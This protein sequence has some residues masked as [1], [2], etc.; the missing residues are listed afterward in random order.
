ML[1]GMR[2]RPATTTICAAAILGAGAATAAAGTGGASLAEPAPKRAAS[3]PAVQLAPALFPVAS[4]PQLAAGVTLRKISRRAV[5]AATLAYV[6]HARVSQQV[7]VDVVRLADGMSVFTDERTVAPEAT[8][9]VSWNGR[10]TSGLALD[11]RYRSLYGDWA[12]AA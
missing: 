10:A 8:Q 6:S 4:I 1:R 11:G 5:S 2:V 3:A 9:K 12:A 7:R